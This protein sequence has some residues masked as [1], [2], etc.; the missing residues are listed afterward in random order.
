MEF[1]KQCYLRINNWHGMTMDDIRAFEDTI[2]VKLD[3][4]KNSKNDGTDSISNASSTS[5]ASSKN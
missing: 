3:E 4:L 1:A 5:V 2:K